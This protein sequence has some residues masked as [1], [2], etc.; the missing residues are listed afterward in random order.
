MDIEWSLQAQTDLQ[1]L[2]SYISKNSPFYARQ[3]D[4]PSKTA[5]YSGDDLN[6]KSP[7]TPPF[8]VGEPFD[9]T[10]GRLQWLPRSKLRGIAN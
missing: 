3:K 2:H 1:C 5:G 10:Q 9:K 7:Y 8:P 6:L 4:P